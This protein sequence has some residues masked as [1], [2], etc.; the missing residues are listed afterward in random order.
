MSLES[1][2]IRA[3][4]A[5]GR[6]LMRLPRKWA[7]RARH[8]RL[9]RPLA[10]ILRH[11]PLTDVDTFT[12]PDDPSVR[13]AGTNSV[14]VRR[15]Y[16]Y[17]GAGYEG[18]ELYWWKRFCRS[19]HHIVEMGANIGFYTVQAGLAAPHARIIAVEPHPDAVEA[20]KRNLELNGIVNVELVAAAAVGVRTSDTV[21]LLLPDTEQTPAPAGGY[22]ESA[23]VADRP[24]SRTIEVRSVAAS[25][26]VAGADLLKLDIEGLEADV[27]SSAE[28][29]VVTARPVIFVEVIRSADKLRALIADWQSKHDYVVFA[30]GHESLHLLPA[31]ILRSPALLPRYGTRDVILVPQERVS[32]I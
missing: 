27:L 1:L 2:R 30:I 23:E 31:D 4:T 5:L 16:W 22:V 14:L 10:V 15:L 17:G 7:E 21:K 8:A 18:A 32:R 24:A 12:L 6:V 11:R 9:I 13:L 19:A 25:E 26:L 29:A 20:I 28:S 3:R